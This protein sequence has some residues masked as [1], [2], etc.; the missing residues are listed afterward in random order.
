MNSSYLL[1][2]FAEINAFFPVPLHNFSILFVEIDR[3][4]GEG[5]EV[6]P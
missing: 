6:L 1:S 3:A 4:V 2:K 5:F